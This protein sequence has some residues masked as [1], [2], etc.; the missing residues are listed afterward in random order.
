MVRWG[1]GARGVDRASP[2]SH[3]VL[4]PRLMVKALVL[5]EPPD[6]GAGTPLTGPVLASYLTAMAPKLLVPRDQQFL[7]A[8]WDARTRTMRLT[9]A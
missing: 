2:L 1:L 7:G 9:L 8:E 5:G 6:A 3:H 4:D